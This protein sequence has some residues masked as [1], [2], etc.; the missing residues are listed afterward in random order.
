MHWWGLFVAIAVACAGCF[1][2]DPGCDF[3]EPCPEGEV[4]QCINF[5]ARIATVEEADEGDVLCALNPCDDVYDVARACPEGYF[6]APGLS[7]GAEVFGRCQPDGPQ[8]GSRC[9]GREGDVLPACE[10]RTFCMNAARCERGQ[11][12]TQLTGITSGAGFCFNPVREGELCDSN[13]SDARGN[14]REV[15]GG[16][17]PCE[18]GTVCAPSE[19]GERRCIRLCEE[20]GARV[21]ELC[22]CQGQVCEDRG[23]TVDPDTGERLGRFF[24]SECNLNQT[25]DCTSDDECCDP[26]ASCVS[27]TS[28]RNEDLTQCCR[29]EGATCDPAGFRECCGDAFCEPGSRT[30][31]A[32]A[33]LGEEVAN[34]PCCPGLEAVTL[35]EGEPPVCRAC[36]F[37]DDKFLCS[38]QSLVI[39]GE[40]GVES[41]PIPN[42]SVSYRETVGHVSGDLDL[43]RRDVQEV[44]W[45]LTEDH[46]AFFFNTRLSNGV[47]EGNEYFSLPFNAPPGVPDS[48]GID[49]PSRWRSVRVYDAGEC[50]LFLP[51]ENLAGIIGTEVAKEALTGSLLDP[52]EE[53]DIDL[54]SLEFVEVTPE[55]RASSQFPREF[56]LGPEDADDRLTIRVRARVS[57]VLLDC[58]ILTLTARVRIRAE[59]AI[60]PTSPQDGVFAS[61]G[62]QLDDSV[63][64]PEY[65]CMLPVFNESTGTWSVQRQ[66]IPRLL[67]DQFQATEC[68][69]A[70]I[71]DECDGLDPFEAIECQNRCR[72]RCN[73]V[74]PVEFPLS[75]GDLRAND[76][77]ARAATC[78]I[79]RDNYR[80]VLLPDLRRVEAEGIDGLYQNN[81]IRRRAIDIPRPV[82]TIDGATDV[83]LRVTGVDL[84]IDDERRECRFQDAVLAGFQSCV[85]AGLW[86]FAGSLT[87]ILSTA[88][89]IS[90]TRDFGIPPGDVRACS[91][92]DDCDGYF[93]GVRHSCVGGRCEQLF[94]EPR[95]LAIR[96]D[97]FEVV[98][99]EDPGDPQRPLVA[100]SGIG[101]RACAPG[102]NRQRAGT[103]FFDEGLATRALQSGRATFNAPFCEDSDVNCAGICAELGA[104]CGGG[105]YTDLTEIPG[106]APPAAALC[107]AGECCIPA[108]VC[109]GSCR[110]LDSDPT[111]CGECGVT[112]D[113]GEVCNEQECCTP[114]SICDDRC[115]DLMSDA[116]NC[117][118]CGRRCGGP[119][120]I[121]IG[122]EC[123]IGDPI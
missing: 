27:Y 43:T 94:I 67:F 109:D 93:G 34:A 77:R 91:T 35:R 114:A 84:D 78:F 18:L 17:L 117:G 79:A 14:P 88:T 100:G 71:V 46:R 31:M 66:V 50:S 59:P 32:C 7:D 96:P 101:F 57:P 41:V 28:A 15:F 89:G 1:P 48:D 121:C 51:W 44:A 97:G 24:C 19:D 111:N 98:L 30:C 69:N 23:E 99:A 123:F 105:A 6:C 95:R 61:V 87:D 90:A 11:A 20:E 5:C 12:W 74:G 3:E 82:V 92:N 54:R 53:F 112:C 119:I 83:V 22:A 58:G 118:A 113:D 33:R 86:E 26:L 70:C 81:V 38:P 8:F 62:C 76:V 68:R 16:C 116:N 85:E 9:G 64:N 2:T 60:E 104:P 55:L 56:P 106:V 73:D 45:N 72:A 4:R 49:E 122:G 120:P 25:R 75:A 108:F 42:T 40:D 102:N 29:A 115:R 21:P 103:E 63:L 110:D 37:F 39:R 52:L 10:E 36:G 65:V 47:N 80:C 13:F 107:T